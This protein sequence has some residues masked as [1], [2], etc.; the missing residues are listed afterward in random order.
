MRACVGDIGRA[1]AGSFSRSDIYVAPASVAV[2]V[3]NGIDGRGL[4]REA[5]ECARDF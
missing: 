2:I 3:F 1:A 5:S 4:D